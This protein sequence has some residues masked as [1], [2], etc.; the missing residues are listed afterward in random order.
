LEYR[1]DGTANALL[2]ANGGRSGI[3]IG[4]FASGNTV[5]RYTPEECE[6]LQ[7]FPT[8]HTKIKF[9][10]KTATDNQRY[11][12][13]GNSM[14]VNAMRWIGQRIVLADTIPAQSLWRKGRA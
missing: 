13:V 6:R 1:A 4:A 8:G 5:R 9:D 12:A 7:G 2:T 10:G 3:G 11:F 14:A